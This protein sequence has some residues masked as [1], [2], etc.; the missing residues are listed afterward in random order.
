MKKLNKIITLALTAILTLT[1]FSCKKDTDVAG[2]EAKLPAL[3]LSSLG[4][5]QTGPFASTQTIQLMFGA[6]TTN[7]ATGAFRIEILNGTSAS[8][9][10]LR[11]INF[12]SWRGNDTPAAGTTATNHSITYNLLPT[13]YQNTN[14][15][16]GSILLKLSA[17]NLTSG[18]TYSIRATAFAAN[19]TSSSL[20]QT[21]FLKMQ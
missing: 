11:T 18:S 17:L 20:T 10:V 3:Q 4:T 19:G 13:T 8:S 2:T 12:A 15:Y 1:M 21:S 6:T 16:G 9:A 14:V 7:T 5:Q